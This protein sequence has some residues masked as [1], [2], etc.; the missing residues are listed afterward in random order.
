MVWL[1]V[2]LPLASVVAGISLLV[3]SARS[4]SIDAVADPV[5]RTA[6]IQV[7]DL[8]PDERARQLQLTAIVRVGARMIEVLPVTGEFDRSAPLRIALHHPSLASADRVVLLSPG[9][10]GWRGKMDLDGSHDWSLQVMAAD[11]DWRL[12]GRLPKGQLAA[13]VKPALESP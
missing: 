13:H 5:Q 8:G 10:L 4:G 12:R 7:S 2:A 6:Q 1:I 9:Q 11:G 3:I